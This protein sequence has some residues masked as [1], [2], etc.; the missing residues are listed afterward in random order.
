VGKGKRRANS[1]LASK[2]ISSLRLP[3]DSI[4]CARGST[5][6]R[7]SGEKVLA[8]HLLYPLQVH[9]PEILQVFLTCLPAYVACLPQ[10]HFETS[11]PSSATVYHDLPQHLQHLIF[12]SAAAPLD[13]CKASAAIAQDAS[14]VATWLLAQ[15]QQPLLTAVGHNMW[16]VC[17]HL[18][19]T[20]QYV[21]DTEELQDALVQS[22]RSGATAVVATLLQWCCKEH[23]DVCRAVKDALEGAASNGHVAACDLLAQHPCITIQAVRSAVCKAAGKGRLDV[24]Q[25]LMRSYPD[26]A[27]P[28]LWGYPMTEAAVSGQ[29]QAMQLLVQHGADIHGTTA[30]PWTSH[31]M[32]SLPPLHHA[33]FYNHI[34]AVQWLLQR[35]ADVRQLALATQLGNLSTVRLLQESGRDISTW[36]GIAFEAAI[37]GAIKDR[38]N[39]EVLLQLLSLSPPDYFLPVPHPDN[40]RS[41]Q[42]VRV[43]NN[44]LEEIQHQQ[45]VRLLQAAVQHGHTGFAQ[46]LQREGVGQ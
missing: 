45:A 6:A 9:E 1:D 25:M 19:S 46:M 21:P 15:N 16:D 30:T 38:D 23:S 3:T 5:E 37:A 43:V 32:M 27:S 33:A 39:V 26:A 18:F 41:A 29:V 34:P 14:L 42:F 28:G 13:T 7:S 35:G 17:G 2:V 4:I 10:M 31:V 22:A 20:H 12:A 11:D 40:V 8:W 44:Y 36:G 24:L